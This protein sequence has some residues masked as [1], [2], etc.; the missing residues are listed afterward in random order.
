MAQQMKSIEELMQLWENTFGI[1]RELEGVTEADLPEGVTGT[2][3]GRKVGYAGP[4]SLQEFMFPEEAARGRAI[5]TM[6]PE[7]WKQAMASLG[8]LMQQH[9]ATLGGLKEA[10][11]RGAFENRILE[12][13]EALQPTPGVATPALD[14]IGGQ[15]GEGVATVGQAAPTTSVHEA[16]RLKKFKPEYRGSPW[17]MKVMEYLMDPREIDE[18]DPLRHATP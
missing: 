17:M 16:R 4:K 2:I 6:H 15:A 9:V 7:G 12:Q 1:P 14:E 11:V 3:R 18:D 8:G 5:P 13:L 10:G